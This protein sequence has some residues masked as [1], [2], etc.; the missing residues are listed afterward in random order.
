MFAIFVMNP[1]PLSGLCIF[2]GGGCKGMFFPVH[3]VC[4]QLGR[5]YSFRLS[6]GNTH[7]VLG[8][9]FGP[10]GL[11]PRLASYLKS[12]V[13]LLRKEYVADTGGA[14]FNRGGAAVRGMLV[15]LL[16]TF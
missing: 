3:Q 9:V 6:N 11:V 10:L 4:H 16:S 5:T 1:H 7:P 15:S 2:S 13:L 8:P 12:P 14:G